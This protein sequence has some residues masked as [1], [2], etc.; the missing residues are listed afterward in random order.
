MMWPSPMH[1]M[2]NASQDWPR[3]SCARSR[4]AFAESSATPEMYPVAIDEF[5]R[6][7]IRRFPFEIFS[8][9]SPEFITVYSVL[10]C[11][12]DPQKWRERLGE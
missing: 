4:H 12:Q 2:R 6:A 5:R 11:S 7:P 1:G 10:H 9:I 3:N 8:E